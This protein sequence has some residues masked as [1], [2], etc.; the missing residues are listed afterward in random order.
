MKT[1]NRNIPIASLINWDF[2]S[3]KVLDKVTLL[4]RSV[5]ALEPTDSNVFFRKNRINTV[6]KIETETN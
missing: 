4:V 3:V 1:K 5:I 6:N 2:I